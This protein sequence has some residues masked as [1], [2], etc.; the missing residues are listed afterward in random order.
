MLLWTFARLLEAASPKRDGGASAGKTR[1][2]NNEVEAMVN[3]GKIKI[4]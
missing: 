4:Q 3:H 1:P 2:S